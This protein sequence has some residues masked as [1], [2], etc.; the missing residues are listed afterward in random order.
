MKRFYEA[1]LQSDANFL[2]KDRKQFLKQPNDCAI[3]LQA[4]RLFH[5]GLIE[6]RN[7]L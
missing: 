7:P 1:A 2:R 3:L 4:A 5:V 6:G